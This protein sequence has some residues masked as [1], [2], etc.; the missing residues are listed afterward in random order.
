M[1]DENLKDILNQ[2]KNVDTGINNMLIPIL[3]DTITYGNKHNKRIFILSIIELFIIIIVSVTAMFF[4]YKQNIQ[5]QEFLSQFE[6]ETTETIY[7]D[8]DDNSTI[9]SGINFSR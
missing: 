2:V 3:Q 7:Q 6:F 8:T 9:N 4:I 1:N 5:Y